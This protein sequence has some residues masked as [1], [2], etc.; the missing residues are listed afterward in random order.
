MTAAFDPDLILAAIEECVTVVKPGEVL[1]V[2]VPP[3]V[4][5][6]TVDGLREGS[7]Q[8]ADASGMTVVFLPGEA[9]ARITTA[10]GAA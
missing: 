5:E 6:D 8:L 2:R 1:A 7:R 10:P 9:F 4:D 3:D